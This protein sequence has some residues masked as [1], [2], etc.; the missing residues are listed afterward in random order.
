MRQAALKTVLRPGA[1]E[2]QLAQAFETLAQQA[3][4]QL[5]L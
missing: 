2:V 4:P 5:G 3:E 1:T